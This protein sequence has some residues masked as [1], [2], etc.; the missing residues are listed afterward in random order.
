M[1]TQAIMIV[2][3]P[4]SGKSLL[5]NRLTGANQKVANFPGVTV[6]IRTA[7]GGDTTYI[8][9][10]GI[11]S[12]NPIS[13]DEVVAVDRLREALR[14]GRVGA[15]LCILDATRLSRSLYLGLQIQLEAN[16]AGIPVVFA[17]NMMDDIRRRGLT[18]D[19]EGLSR[20][21]NCP[22]VPIS[23][24]T[25]DGLD[26]LRATLRT[27][28]D[29]A[30]PVS[31]TAAAFSNL[32]LAARDLAKTFGPPTD[33][34]LRSQYRMDRILLSSWWGAFIFIA[35]MALLFQSIFT[36]AT[37]LM[38]GVESAIAY[39]GELVTASLPDGILRDFINDAL[40]GGIGSFLVF[41]PQIFVMTLIIGALE[42]S[43]YL[44]R[45]AVIC[46]RPLA[47][48]GLSGRSFV[49]LLSGHACAIPAIFA[50]RTI[51]SPRRRF[52]TILAIPFMSCS[53]R[54]PV[55]TLIVAALFPATTYFGGIIGIQ[56]LIFTGVYLFGVLTALIVSAIVDRSRKDRSN[57]TP[58]VIE[59]PPYRLPSLVPSARRAWQSAMAFVTKA[60]SVIFFV[61]VI[62]WLL[63]YFPNGSGSL[64]SS[65]L[66]YIGRAISPVFEPLGLDWR[67]GVA[68]L[69]SFVAREVFVGTLGTLFGIES[70]DE[71]IEGLA[72]QVQAS[73]LSIASGVA[74]LAFY[75]LALQCASTL[76][77]I[78]KETG[79]NRLPIVLFLAYGLLAYI[80]ALV[81]YW[82]VQL[83]TSAI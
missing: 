72:S 48:F 45:A 12:V 11:Y 83:V 80:A 26:Q 8:D 53:A 59:M 43:G 51:E 78:R 61:T 17:L 10:P 64:D 30:K 50:A 28:A 49:P 38:D 54:L 34:F 55:Y 18:A 77:V 52:L 65:Y 1:T 27:A 16:H 66:S 13:Q 2:G 23:A 73:G 21:L 7:K 81:A 24:R 46:H 57:D 41:V 63:G 4:N 37:P 5:F 32:E 74:L 36:W 62:V 15:V 22:V 14:G 9:F 35:I 76:A 68:I 58:F 6:E 33:V 25:G 47:A 40:F 67:Y 56:G 79:S 75:A 82:L 29:R 19:V 44:T 69:A 71:N 42:D 70:A 39:L 20:S 60:G 31:S 3:K